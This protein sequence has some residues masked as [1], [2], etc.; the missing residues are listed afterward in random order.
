VPVRMCPCLTKCLLACLCAWHTDAPGLPIAFVSVHLLFCTTQEVAA[1]Q[2][3]EGEATK[4]AGD[5]RSQLAKAESDKE[6][7]MK[8]HH[9]VGAIV[10]PALPRPYSLS[11][12]HTHTHTCVR[13]GSRAPHPLPL[14]SF[15]LKKG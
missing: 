12:A 7:G 1:L 5:L 14:S 3:K 13:F 6:A 10:W 8:E 4:L 15:A 2:R 11:H 9:A